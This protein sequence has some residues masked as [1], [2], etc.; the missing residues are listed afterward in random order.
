MTKRGNFQPSAPTMT[1]W[2]IAIILGLLGILAHFT[3]I[4]ELSR[5]NYEM[6]LIA[7]ILLAV[8]TSYRRV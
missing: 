5:Y 8:G 7:F 6:V 2:V 4:G 1:V 3:S